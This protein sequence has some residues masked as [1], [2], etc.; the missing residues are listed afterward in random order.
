MVLAAAFALAA[1]PAAA[2]EF[3]DLRH[4]APPA[5]ASDWDESMASRAR[6]VA[7]ATGVTEPIEAGIEI[8]LDNGWKTYWRHPGDSGIAPVFDFSGSQNVASV[9]VAYPA[10]QRFDDPGDVSFGYKQSVV[11]PL[12]VTPEDPDEPVHLEAH[13]VYG[14]CETVCVPVEAD[15]SLEIGDALAATTPFA[16]TLAEWRARVPQDHGFVLERFQPV[17]VEGEPWLHVVVNAGEPMDEASLVARGPSRAY[18]GPPQVT[19]EGT[20]ALF[21]FPVTYRRKADPLGP[22]DTFDITFVTGDA[23][24]AFEYTLGE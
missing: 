13:V 24:Q 22:G 1:A 11:F 15:L 2:L 3:G 4:R 12:R 7:S 18:L 16:V 6:L 8:A 19:V 21:A 17:E 20:R 23:A 10:P 14:A 9:D 5:G